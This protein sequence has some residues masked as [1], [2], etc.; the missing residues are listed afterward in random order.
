M[1]LGAG[2]VLGAEAFTF[3]LKLQVGSTGNEVVE[4]QKFLNN[5]GYDV[6]S[7][8]GIFGARTVTGVMKFEVAN[9]LAGMELWSGFELC[10]INRGARFLHFSQ[11]Y[12]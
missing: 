3:T 4:L 1:P 12:G 10:S 8:D 7:T 6:G 9:N 11:K 5:A 2:S